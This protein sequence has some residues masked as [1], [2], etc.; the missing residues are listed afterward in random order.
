MAEADREAAGHQGLCSSLDVGHA[1]HAQALPSPPVL[2]QAE[3]RRVGGG[4]CGQP[5]RQRLPEHVTAGRLPR[6]CKLRQRQWCR[7]A[8]PAATLLLLSRRRREGRVRGCDGGRRLEQRAGLLPSR[9]WGALCAGPHPE[10]GLQ[11]RAAA[12]QRAGLEFW[13]PG[14]VKRVAVVEG[15]TQLVCCLALVQKPG[16]KVLRRER[17]LACGSEGR[18]PRVVSMAHMTPARRRA[19]GATVSWRAQSGAAAGCVPRVVLELGAM[20]NSWDT[21]LTG[22][23]R[24][25]CA[26]S[27]R[28]QATVAPVCAA[29]LACLA[30]NTPAGGATALPPLRVGGALARPATLLILTVRSNPRR[31]TQVWA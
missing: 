1:Q 23:S 11:Q 15:N 22:A 12:Q 10:A 19:T 16:R 2:R 20:S 24:P 25:Q 14:L 9:R 3:Q 29:R 30:R 31:A 8:H 17:L 5:P 26:G 27:G 7:A 6:V 4:V 18:Q 13:R 21:F 28:P